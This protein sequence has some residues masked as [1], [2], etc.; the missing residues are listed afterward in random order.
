MRLKKR[1]SI[2]IQKAKF[3]MSGIMKYK[4]LITRQAVIKNAIE[5]LADSN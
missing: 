5:I 4:F 1:K 2:K 3:I